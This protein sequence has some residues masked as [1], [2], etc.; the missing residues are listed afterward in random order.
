MAKY[1]ID[2]SKPAEDD[3]RDIVRYISSQLTAPMTAIKMLETIEKALEKLSDLPDRCPVVRDERLTSMGYHRLNV[4]NY[5]V[6]F[7]VDKKTKV[8]DVE[9]ILY[10][11]RDWANL[12]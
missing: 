7:T 5:V 6:L 2:V 8:V 10:S 12:L 1:R 3:L 4:K 11:R 9:R